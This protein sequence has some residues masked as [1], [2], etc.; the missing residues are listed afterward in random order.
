V[1][2]TKNGCLKIGRSGLELQFAAVRHLN[3]IIPI[4]DYL[5]FRL[6]VS[7]PLDLTA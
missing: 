3:V 4:I 5:L 7:Q 2:F 6:S 1:F